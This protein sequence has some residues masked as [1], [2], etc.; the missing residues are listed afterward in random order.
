MRKEENE[1]RLISADRL[2]PKK[3]FR[4]VKC[5][6]PPARPRVYRRYRF[7]LENEKGEAGEYCLPCAARLLGQ[8]QA[9]LRQAADSGGKTR[10]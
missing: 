1:M 7:R 9:H 8:S 6:P 10:S 3:V 2:E 4:C 5:N